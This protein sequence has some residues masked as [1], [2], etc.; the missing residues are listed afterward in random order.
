MLLL[1]LLMFLT[2]RNGGLVE[3][4]AFRSFLSTRTGGGGNRRDILRPRVSSSSD[5]SVSTSF[6]YN[7]AAIEREFRGKP[8]EVWQRLVDIGR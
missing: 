7:G 1:Y 6:V 8:F 3:C 4:L 2:F 5:S